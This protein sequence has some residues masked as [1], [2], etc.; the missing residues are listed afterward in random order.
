MKKYY[1][2]SLNKIYIIVLIFIVLKLNLYL[3]SY[4]VYNNNILLQVTFGSRNQTGFRISNEK[5][6]LT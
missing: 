2:K 6:W 3:N 5:Y 4:Y 1:G